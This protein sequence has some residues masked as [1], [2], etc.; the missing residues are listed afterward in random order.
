MDKIYIFDTTLRDGEQAPGAS[1]NIKEKIEIA[2]QLERL[3]VDVIEAG[4]PIAS[5]GDF[6]AVSLIAKKVKKPTICALARSLK[7]DIDA[8]AGALKGAK[9]RRIHVFLA[10]SKIHMKYKLKKAEDEILK[11]A[12]K[13]VEYAGKFSD[14]V[15]FSPEDA[16]RTEREFL[17]KIIAE[18][19]NAGAGVVNIPDTV[20]Y[21]VPEE[22]SDLITQINKNV[23]NIDD[24]II[25]VH[26][27]DDLGLSCAN[28]LSA[29]KAG[30]RQV[31]CT[32]NGIG[33]RAGS[34]PLEEIV[35]AIK[36][37]ADFYKSKTSIKTK[38]LYKSS[39]LVSLLMGITLPP[40]KAVIGDNAFS[41][42][43][44]IHQDGVLKMPKT[45]EIMSPSDVGFKESKLVL[46]KHSG[47]HAFSRKLEELGV[48][49]SKKKFQKAYEEFIALADKKKEV[50]DD[51]IIA[52][53]ED[54]MK[55]VPKVWE[56]VYVHTVTG[57]STIP[58]ATVKL[59]KDKKIYEDA[60]C[61][62]GPIDA[63]YNTIDRIIGI[64]PKL[65]NYNLRAVTSGR[66]ALGEVTVRLKHKN[67]EIVARG[68][69]TDIVEASTKAYLNAVNK[70]VS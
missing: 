14:D 38:E 20:G 32:I 16:S 58:T 48:E 30:A 57:S 39:R 33:E 12:V 29:V 67:R 22:F 13:A 40:N 15:E 49:L 11:Q 64:K 62:D 9:K 56:F 45:Y 37:R 7:K 65:L 52:L 24:A 8:A 18:V 34:A 61:G 66:D 53:I 10:T 35:M 69:S 28:S 6:E 4:F 27:H 36:T 26:C 51:D 50:F 25:S 2:K 54:E 41:H 3:N 21:T 63:C 68:T 31:E 23:P 1:L 5:P 17:F 43:S 42:E 44:G 19:I 55:E 60:A 46:G 47:R 70:I 59:R